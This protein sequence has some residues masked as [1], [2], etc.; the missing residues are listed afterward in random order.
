MKT[1]EEKTLS[2][3]LT[4][5]MVIGMIP[6]TA[7]PVFARE[8][9][10][11]G[12]D[13]NA[14]TVR[15]RIPVPDFVAQP[16]VVEVNDTDLI[17]EYTESSTLTLSG[18]VTADI[19]VVGGGGTVRSS[20]QTNHS[21]GGGGGAG[22]FIEKENIT[23]AAGTYEIDVGAGGT[24]NGSSS[25]AAA[26][27]NGR[28]ST[29]KFGDTVLIEATGGGGGGGESIGSVGASGGGGGTIANCENIAKITASDA[30]AG[31][32]VGRIEDDRCTFTDNTNSG[33]VSAP[34]YCGNTCG[35]D[36]KTKTT[37]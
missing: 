23:L 35:Y 19:L 25:S 24:P 29:I 32:M 26:G 12:V 10:F 8:F 17:L 3:L 31:G 13:I 21:G 2:V 6:M 14:G 28:S 15:Y 22:E 20:S 5:V 34:R 27:R 9:I 30:Y 18:T 7:L 16:G 37:Y 36:G 4:I 11:K 33:T 1:N